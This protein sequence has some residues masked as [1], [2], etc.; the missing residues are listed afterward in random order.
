MARLS[1][2]WV[3]ELYSFVCNVRYR[4]F[5]F[6]SKT[7]TMCFLGNQQ[8]MVV[9]I[10][11]YNCAFGW[12]VCFRQLLGNFGPPG[13]AV[14]STLICTTNTRVEIGSHRA[15]EKKIESNETMECIPI[16]KL[17]SVADVDGISKCSGMQFVSVVVL[18]SYTRN[19][20][21]QNGFS[22]F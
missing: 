20:L 19:S 7:V 18:H 15:R 9:C 10:Y 11:F 4:F 6:L 22:R 5:I 12:S 2:P 21:A 1:L 13:H 8:S 16:E 17:A 14:K 3:C